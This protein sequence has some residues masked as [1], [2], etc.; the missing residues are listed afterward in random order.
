MEI[1]P[2]K[3]DSEIQ[4]YIRKHY[5]SV[6][7]YWARRNDVPPASIPKPQVVQKSSAKASWTSVM[8]LPR[9]SA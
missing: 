1:R 8:W 5:G 6:E 9:V 2:L 3:T 4:E 7:E